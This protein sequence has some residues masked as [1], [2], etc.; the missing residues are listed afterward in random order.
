VRT[1]LGESSGVVVRPHVVL[2]SASAL[3][4][5][6][7][8]KYANEV[9]WEWKGHGAD[10]RPLHQQP[11]GWRV[12]GQGYAR[13]YRAQR[14]VEGMP[15]ERTVSGSEVD[16]AALFFLR[17]SNDLNPDKLP[18]R[19][20]ASGYVTDNGAGN[21]WLMGVNQT[22]QV[23]GYPKSS[24]G[25]ANEGLMHRIAARNDY[26]FS[27][28]GEHVFGTRSFGVD[29]GLSGAS[30]WVQ[31]GNSNW[32]PA[33]L[34]LGVMQHNSQTYSVVRA[35]DGGVAHL[36]EEAEGLAVTGGNSSGNQS[37][38]VAAAPVF[39]YDPAAMLVESNLSGEDYR[40]GWQ[41]SDWE[42]Y[43]EFGTEYGIGS[44]IR[45]LGTQTM[46]FNEFAGFVAPGAT[47]V[48]LSTSGSGVLVA[49]TYQASGTTLSAWLGGF[50]GLS[51]L[52]ALG[53]DDRD[54]IPNLLE[55][56]F[57]L[58][59]VQTNRHTLTPG[60]GVSGLPAHDVQKSSGTVTGIQVE[61]LQRK[62]SGLSYSVERSGTPHRCLGNHHHPR[63]HRDRHR[64]HLGACHPHRPTRPHINFQNIRAHQGLLA[65]TRVFLG[66]PV[67]H[68]N[69]AGPFW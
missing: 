67:S 57:N 49:A 11:R 47:P 43:Y 27:Y 16:V 65:V 5:E 24:E 8:L 31:H 2:T 29:R 20:G 48:T 12:Y 19:G 36:I 7:N 21:G 32:Y 40:D 63:A 3:F 46:E 1:E 28:L 41:L 25:T 14:V 51:D 66:N 60:S 55:Y 58:H 59:P 6:V 39:G 18:A 56:A 37:G 35:I 50:S 33:A 17:E 53:D 13:E 52:S 54:G 68:C 26:A 38:A 15:Q 61:W 9:R 30:V 22:R 44:D 64:R 42:D 45:A 10:H 4:D 69:K 34:V 23:L 62:N